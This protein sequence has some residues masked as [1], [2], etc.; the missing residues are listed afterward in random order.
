MKR[1]VVFIMGTL[2]ILFVFMINQK[3]L[4]SS[5]DKE[6][7]TVME[8]PVL[9]GTTFQNFVF[10]DQFD[11]RKYDGVTLNFIVENNINANIL[12]RESEEFTKL[13][14]INVKIR[15][16]DYDTF[17]QKIN[18]D[19]ISETGEYQLIYADPYQTLNRFHDDL[20]VLNPYI[21]NK[22]LPQLQM[23][24]NDFFASSLDVC[25]YF[26]DRD[27]I[28]AVPFDSTTMIMYY[29]KDVF[30]DFKDAFMRS[31]GYDWTPG[32]DD[33][34]WDKYIEISEWIDKYVP[35]EIVEY[36]SGQMSQAHNSIFCEFSNVLASYGGNFFA[37]EAI[38]SVG[39]TTFN[40]LT[41][42]SDAFVE[43]LETYKNMTKVAAPES[44]NWNWTDTAEAFKE[45]RIA[46]MFN[47]DENYTALNDSDNF[48]VNGNVGTC[49]L[50]T[51]P[52]R[53]ANI[54][55]G[56]GIGINRYASQREKEAAWFY[57]TWATSKDMQLRILTDPTGGS[58]PTIKSAYEDL[59]QGFYQKH[60]QVETVL[61]AWQPDHIYYRPK[62]EN[63]Y[64]IEQ[65][66]IEELHDMIADDL[67]PKTVSETLQEQIM[68]E[69]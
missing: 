12:S 38:S 53:S 16:I 46:M 51:G 66:I 28:Y 13:T 36:G 32:G 41:V 39:Q 7:K 1:L 23:A 26:G 56:S 50:P 31:K 67:D 52:V 24:K 30:E 29:R 17:I 43:A 59:D 33:F 58:L 19:F 27:N 18:L 6:V 2:L 42:N 20:E 22:D 65:I 60:P 21:D 64:S 54:Y 55:G 25:S 48:R 47:W 11:I 40:Q 61:K 10:P 68:R 3:E 44:Q 62:L 49:I 57:I 37:D 4:L 63:F 14:G 9:E 34:T 35:N 45:G 15:P 8:P 69:K 5:Q